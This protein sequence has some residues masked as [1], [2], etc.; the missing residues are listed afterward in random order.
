MTAPRPQGA[1]GADKSVHSPP[2]DPFIFEIDRTTPEYNTM[3]TNMDAQANFTFAKDADTV[4][5]GQDGPLPRPKE[6]RLPN[7]SI[8]IAKHSP[9]RSSTTTIKMIDFVGGNSPGSATKLEKKARSI[10]LRE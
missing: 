4:I 3:H 1:I 10:T 9:S 6:R 8:N 5:E 2:E 7:G